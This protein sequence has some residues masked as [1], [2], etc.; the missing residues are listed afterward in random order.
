MTWARSMQSFDTFLHAE[1]N[2]SPHTRRAYGSDLRQ[3]MVSVGEDVEPSDI[4][5]QL[6]RAWLAEQY[7]R[8]SAATVSPRSVCPCLV[9]ASVCVVIWIWRGGGRIARSEQ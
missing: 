1:R 6:V 3:L 9:S 5:A 4:D 7:Q 2:L 8:C